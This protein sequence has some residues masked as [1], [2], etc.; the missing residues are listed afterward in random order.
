MAPTKT[1]KKAART[2]P[3]NT[4]LKSSGIMRLSRGRMFHKRGLWLIEKWKKQ[5]EKKPED[6]K[7]KKATRIV[8]KDIK[9]DKN[10]KTRSVRS[11]RFVSIIQHSKNRSYYYLINPSTYKAQILPDRREAAKVEDQ[12]EVV[13]ATPTQTSNLDHSR[14]CS[15]S[16][17][18][19]SR[20]KS[21]S[22]WNL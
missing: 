10:G 21:K 5:N 22:A 20:W 16:S 7:P 18:W 3:I 12:Q 6:K 8:K 2:Q 13:F 19:S 11:Q 15:Y 4:E 9:G 17:R 1:G 14:H